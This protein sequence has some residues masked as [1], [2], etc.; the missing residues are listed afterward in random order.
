MASYACPARAD[1]PTGDTILSAAILAALPHDA[2]VLLAEG[3]AWFALGWSA[4][5]PVAD[6]ARQRVVLGLDWNPV[7]PAHPVR[8]RL[9]YRFGWRY[10]FF[11]LGASVDRSGFTASPE[12]GVRLFHA[13]RRDKKA[14]F[15]WHFLVRADLS[16]KPERLRAVTYLVGWSIF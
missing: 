9:G 14:N 12:V 16:P 6:L 8:G 7:S 1:L 13:S 2:G 10:P 4:Q 5:I 15:S 3:N 11:G